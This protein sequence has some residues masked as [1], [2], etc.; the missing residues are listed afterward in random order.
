MRAIDQRLHHGREACQALWDEISLRAYSDPAYAR[1]HNLGF[2]AYCM[3]H[4]RYTRSAKSYVAHLTRLCC[5]LE[6]TG[7]PKVYAA[8]RSWLDGKIVLDKPAYPQSTGSLTV[9]NL[10]A[11]QSVE[12]FHRQV[13]IW[14]ENVWA[15]YASQHE[16]ARTWILKALDRHRNVK[17]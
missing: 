11:A 15:A 13:W 12:E 5:G 16:L 10:K 8:I 9:A 4:P 2:D 17:R 6:Y 14:A 3:Q 1:S 7:E